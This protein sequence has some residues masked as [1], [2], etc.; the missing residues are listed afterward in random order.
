MTVEKNFRTYHDYREEGTGR[1]VEDQVTTMA[2]FYPFPFKICTFALFSYSIC[3]L[4]FYIYLTFL[5]HDHFFGV[6]AHIREIPPL[7]IYTHCSGHCL[8]LV[9]TSCS[10][11]MIINVLDKMKATCSFFLNSPKWNRLLSE[12]V[13]KNVTEVSRRKP[14]ID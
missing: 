6:Q 12:I 7:A 5:T 1:E 13:S 10:V 3:Y 11:P 4:A 2:S 14:L 8:N 9:I